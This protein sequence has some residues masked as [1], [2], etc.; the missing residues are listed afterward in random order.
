MAACV[1]RDSPGCYGGIHPEVFVVSTAR[2]EPGYRYRRLWTLSFAPRAALWC[3]LMTRTAHC[4][5]MP[6]IRNLRGSYFF[7]G[8]GGERGA[9]F[10]S[11][12]LGC[13]ALP[14]PCNFAF[15]FLFGAEKLVWSFFGQ[16]RC[17]TFNLTLAVSAAPPKKSRPIEPKEVVS[18][19]GR[20]ACIWRRLIA[21]KEPS[22]RRLGFT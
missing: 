4:K 10:F 1:T 18:N 14:K 5:K 16:I 6:E 9:R 8:R 17:F 22:C 21:K 2:F 11:E 3:R 15:F 13:S 12:R 20:G 7:R 19:L